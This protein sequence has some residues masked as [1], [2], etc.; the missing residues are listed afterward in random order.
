MREGMKPAEPTGF[1]DIDGCLACDLAAGRRPLPGGR[2]HETERW[3]VEHCVGPLGVGTLLV[4]PRRHVVTLGD[5][6]ADEAAELGPLLAR[7]G[8]VVDRLV[9]PEQVYVGLW[10][11]AGRERVH[12][13]FVV[14][15]ATTGAI[16]AV[17]THGPGLPTGM[18]ERGEMP[19]P[20]AV[21]EFCD[22]ARAVFAR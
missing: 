4:K 13:H 1:S 22:R 10:S 8:A 14:Q 3:I 16:D 12:I 6:R 2:I 7:S 15:P 5:L 20:A 21:A 19:D 17:G 18:F 11:H 9:A